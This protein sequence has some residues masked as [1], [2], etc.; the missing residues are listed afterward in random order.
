MYAGFVH[1]EGPPDFGAD[2]DS[3]RRVKM[4]PR[5]LRTTSSGSTNAISNGPEWT[6]RAAALCAAVAHAN[7]EV[8]T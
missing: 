4:T 7:S 6:A 2:Q 3:K 1:A 5:S 8:Q